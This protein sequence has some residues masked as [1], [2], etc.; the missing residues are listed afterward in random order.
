MTLAPK[1]P[2]I[3]LPRPGW[4]PGILDPRAQQL[5]VNDVLPERIQ[6]SV[7]AVPGQV[8]QIPGQVARIAPA[9]GSMALEMSGRPGLYRE[10]TNAPGSGRQDYSDGSTRSRP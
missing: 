1:P 10:A 3:N 4:S 7:D 8:A 5:F 9:A 2:R 6:E